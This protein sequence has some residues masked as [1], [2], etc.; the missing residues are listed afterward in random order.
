MRG[1]TAFAGLLALG[2]CGAAQDTN[3]MTEPLS[4]INADAATG[5]ALFASRDGGHCVLCHAVTGLS[6][7][8]QGDLGPS[9]D[10]ISDRLNEAELRLRIAN[11]RQV[12]PDTVM[13]AYYKS[14]GF[15][16]VASEYA[17]ETV[18]SGEEIEHIIAYLMTLKDE[19]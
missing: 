16:Q 14:G 11:P 1:A 18:L 6:A 13:P 12:W 4:P 9:L 10:G 5:E 17:G 19:G 8:F 7:E 3:G 15:N 2:A